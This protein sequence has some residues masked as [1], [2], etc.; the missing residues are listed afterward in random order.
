MQIKQLINYTNSN[1]AHTHW[2]HNIV[3][4]LIIRWKTVREEQKDQGQFHAE[5]KWQ[6]RI[7]LTNQCSSWLSNS[8]SS[9]ASFSCTS[10][11]QSI[12]CS[13]LMRWLSH[14][15]FT[16]KHQNMMNIFIYS[17]NLSFCWIVSCCG[18]VCV[19]VW[20][21]GITKRARERGRQ[22]RKEGAYISRALLW[23]C[24]ICSGNFVWHK[25]QHCDIPSNLN[26]S[27]TEI[28]LLKLNH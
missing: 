9:F 4:N 18:Y 10:S 2:M 23:H 16:Q 22:W 5:S 21:S 26:K 13:H 20:V 25:F 6:N 7:D 28:K 24:L 11:I 1:S 8:S 27:A 17:I 15:H 3:A 12:T 14:T 19:R